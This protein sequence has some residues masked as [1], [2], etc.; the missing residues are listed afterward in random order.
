MCVILKDP[1]LKS[2]IAFST[3][4]EVRLHDTGGTSAKEPETSK[5]RSGRAF[6]SSKAASGM[7]VSMNST[8]A[9][10]QSRAD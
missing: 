1:T 7:S 2:T 8:D 6:G 10:S 3:D 4:V 9:G 5:N